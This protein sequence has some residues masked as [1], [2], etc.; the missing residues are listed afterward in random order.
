MP[1][2]RV[3]VL[4]TLQVAFLGGEWVLLFREKEKSSLKVPL[5]GDNVSW[6][7]S[8]LDLVVGGSWW[9]LTFFCFEQRLKP[10]KACSESH[11]VSP[12]LV[13]PKKMADVKKKQIICLSILHSVPGHLESS[14][15]TYFPC[16][17][18]DSPKSNHLVWEW[19]SNFL[20][21]SGWFFPPFPGVED[22]FRFGMENSSAASGQ[23]VPWWCTSPRWCQ[24]PIRVVSTP[25]AA[26]SPAPLLQ[27]GV[28]RREDGEG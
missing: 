18:F 25:S 21:W 27:V 2:P 9:Q 14:P 16:I 26:S 1:P 12:V 5:G 23:Q 11:R 8:I 6:Q 19:L 17:Y 4:V 3:S 24:P 10:W 22:V 13:Q 28:R 7:E 20:W 15:Y